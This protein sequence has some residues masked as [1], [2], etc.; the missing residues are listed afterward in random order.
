MIFPIKNKI[1]TS[2]IDAKHINLFLV[3][4]KMLINSKK[5][6]IG[7]VIGATFAAFIVMQQ[8]SVYQGVTDRLVSPIR[9]VTEPDLWVMGVNSFSFDQPTYFKATDIY[10]VRGVPGVLWAVPLYR[11]W[12]SMKHLNTKKTERWELVGVDPKSLIGLPKTMMSGV[13]SNIH[14]ANAILVDGYSLKQLETENKNTI[15]M[16]DKLI[17]GQNTWIVSGITGPLRTYM[18]EPKA[19][20]IS[21]HIPNVLYQPSFILVKVKPGFDIDQVASDIHKITQYLALTTSEFVDR[22]NRYFREQTP[23]VMG[24]I[25]IATIGFI[26]GLVMMWQIFNNFVITHLHQFGML[27]MLGVSS[28]LLMKMVLFQATVTGGLG[29]L[30]GLLLTVLFGLIFYDTVIAFHLTGQIILL[31]TVGTALV[32]AFASYFGILKVIRLDTVEL[33]RDSN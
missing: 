6:F 15:Q 30:I 24:F 27:K 26:I 21:S 12:Y 5:R 29:Y 3:A 9:A 32:V 20:M 17:E 10:R 4:F 25:S 14:N 19:Y 11:M 22:S 8:P 7:M 23:I 1:K 18:I 16:G 13:R 33:C 2:L 31:G 28:S